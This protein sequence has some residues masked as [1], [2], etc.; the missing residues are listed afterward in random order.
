M[1][2]AGVE[3]WE[4]RYR[5]GRT[6][7]E[8]GRPPAA[9]LRQLERERAG[10]GAVLVP[11]CGSG[12]EIE[13]WRARGWRVQAVD[14]SPAAVARARARLGA[15]TGACV[16]LA[17]FFA[18]PTGDA[19]AFDVVY[20]RTFLCSFPRERW[21]D[22][23]RCVRA[24]LRPGGR[25]MGVFIYGHEPEP[26]PYPLASV[27]EAKALLRGLVLETDEPIP[28]EETLPLYTGMERWQVWRRE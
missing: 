25:L 3:F 9:L 19:G 2:S 6:P 21:V 11:G 7:W 22:Y 8:M 18:L 10:G 12:H 24:H 28:V 20:E 5:A 15:E 23:A 27:A 26:P 14:F 1:D 4:E 16:E 13:A 17:D